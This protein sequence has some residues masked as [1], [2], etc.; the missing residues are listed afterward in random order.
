MGTLRMLNTTITAWG[1]LVGFGPQ[2]MHLLRDLC[3]SGSATHIYRTTKEV[4]RTQVNQGGAM[5]PGIQEVVH[6]E[7]WLEDP[8]L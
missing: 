8:S 4:N 5:V 2:E 6:S 1:I 3:E 7:H